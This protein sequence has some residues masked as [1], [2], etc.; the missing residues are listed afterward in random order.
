MQTPP[1]WGLGSLWEDETSEE[2]GI[3][4]KSTYNNDQI[5]VLSEQGKRSPT[6]STEGKIRQKLFIISNLKIYSALLPLL[7]SLLPRATHQ[8]QFRKGIR[9]VFRGGRPP[10]EPLMPHGERR[11]DTCS[12]LGNPPVYWPFRLSR[13]PACPRMV[14]RGC[15]CSPSLR[16]ASRPCSRPSLSPLQR[17]Q[18]HASPGREKKTTEKHKHL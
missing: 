6:L 3:A 14:P 5:G 13:W 11:A 10:L 17:P 16:M 9:P 12:G 1:A 18:S 7:L 4:K 2:R 8:R 15:R